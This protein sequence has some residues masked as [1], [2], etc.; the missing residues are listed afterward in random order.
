[1][2]SCKKIGREIAT[3]DRGIKDSCVEGAKGV[4]HCD[5]CDDMA[6]RVAAALQ[7]E[8]DRTELRLS[9]QHLIGQQTGSIVVQLQKAQVELEA[10][11]GRMESAARAMAVDPR[12]WAQHRRDAW[13]YALVVGWDD[14]LPNIIEQHGRAW[15]AKAVA[16]LL[17]LLDDKALTG[18]VA[19]VCAECPGGVEVGCPN[20]DYCERQAGEFSDAMK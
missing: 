16:N 14:A 2:D 5:A 11:K 20:A 15:G 17:G 6:R 4:G 18:M 1:M 12:D 10:L 8:R 7:I 19:P 9:S 3:T 13:L